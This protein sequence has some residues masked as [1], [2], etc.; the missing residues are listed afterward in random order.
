MG[1]LA[2]SRKHLERTL[3][4]LGPGPYRNIWEGV[5]A[6]RSAEWLIQ[7]AAL[8]GYPDTALKRAPRTVICR[9]AF[10]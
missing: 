1:D 8:C 9:P 5:Q 2:T 7:I 4:L 10:L 6:R 3:E